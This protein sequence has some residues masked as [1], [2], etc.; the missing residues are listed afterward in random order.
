MLRK[1]LPHA[2]IIISVMYFVFYFIDRVNPAM[3]FI[4]NGMTKVL[5]CILGVISILE[6]VCLIRENRARERSRQ[7]RLRRQRADRERA[8]GR[9]QG[10]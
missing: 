7:E 6:S 9:R 5:I 1:L 4:N 2:A 8:E 3:A 10:Y